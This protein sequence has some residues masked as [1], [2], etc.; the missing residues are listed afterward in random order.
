MT[1]LSD[2]IL[3]LLTDLESDRVERTTSTNKTDKFCEV[4]CAFSNDMPNHRQPGYLLIG[5]NDDGTLS[6]LKVTD[7]L[8]KN[9]AAN[10]DNGQ[11]Q[12]LP[13]MAVE[14]K[15]YPDG[16]IAFVKVTPSPTP[17]VRYQG[18]T[19][20]RVGPRRATATVEE[21]R[22]LSE[23]RLS[24]AVSYD[25]LPCR[26]SALADISLPI[27]RDYRPQAVDQSIIDENHR[28]IE[29][30]LASLSFFDLTTRCPTYGG[31][32][33]F[34][35]NPR[36][37]IPGAYIQYLQYPGTESTDLPVD[38]AEISGD[39][40]T[41]LRE[42]DAR[43]RLIIKSRPVATQGLQES[44]YS[45][46]PP[47]AL[48]ELLMNAVMHRDYQ[49]TAPIRF[50]CFSDRIEI[51]SPGGLYGGVTPDNFQSRNPSSYRNPTIA[52]AMKN[53]DYVNK[54]GT[55]ISRARSELAKNGNPPAEFNFESSHSVLVIIR[56]KAA[57]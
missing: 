33:L 45:N 46:Y 18:R 34:G 27:F 1:D 24:L 22:C 30:Q 56:E 29:L 21:E 16:D 15:S 41:V 57:A 49:S 54:F 28:D 23:R 38:E 53:L 13:I 32:L 5:V 20:I 11:I 35:I 4:I 42:L 47:T 8:L 12:P 26:N 39:L 7:D 6:G 17:P 9:L 31:I 44:R 19:W 48:R 51:F 3:P 55:G 25:A 14:K 2:E 10:R 50:Y 43:M 36:Q 40:L 52:V 37:F